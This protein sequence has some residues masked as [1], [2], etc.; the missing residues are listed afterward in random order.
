ML[1]CKTFESLEAQVL[2]LIPSPDEA[3]DDVIIEVVEVFNLDIGG[4]AVERV[5]QSHLA[6]HR[7]HYL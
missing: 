7:V 4:K 5:L 2:K 3:D 6:R 1:S